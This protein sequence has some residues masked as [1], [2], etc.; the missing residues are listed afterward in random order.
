M[1]PRVHRVYG[2]GEICLVCLFPIMGVGRRIT[3]AT[4]TTH[5]HVACEA[6]ALR[7]LGAWA[8][9]AEIVPVGVPGATTSDKM[10]TRGATRNSPQ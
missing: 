8:A 3:W 9:G 6:A 5:S 1:R 2:V 4:L 7:L 10:E